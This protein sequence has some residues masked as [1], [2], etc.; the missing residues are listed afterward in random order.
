MCDDDFWLVQRGEQ[1]GSLT[2]KTVLSRHIS[3]ITRSVDGCINIR[4]NR[5]T[6]HDEGAEILTWWDN[7]FGCM[8]HTRSNTNNIFTYTNTSHHISLIK[9]FMHII[10]IVLKVTQQTKCYLVLHSLR[11]W[12]MKW[13]ITVHNINDFEASWFVQFT[14]TYIIIVFSWF[15]LSP[16][17]G[18][19]PLMGGGIRWRYIGW[20][21]IMVRLVDESVLVLWDWM[22]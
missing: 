20:W 2:D 17:C 1:A 15:T 8:M 21:V 9:L 4:Y 13:L 19:P 11:R 5:W 22:R 12:R 6:E 10:S 18:T 3:F 16:S 14:F 7:H